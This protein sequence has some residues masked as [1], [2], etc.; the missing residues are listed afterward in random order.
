MIER[1]KKKRKTSMKSQMTVMKEREERLLN[2]CVHFTHGLALIAI[3]AMQKIICQD[4]DVIVEGMKNQ[5]TQ[6]WFCLILVENIVNKKDMKLVH[7]QDAIYFAIQ[8]AAHLVLLKFL[9]LVFAAKNSK[10]FNAKIPQNKNSIA[11]ILV[12]NF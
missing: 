10:E 8:E 5:V 11:I 2:K 7:M 12:A 9:F 1:K 3:I 4:I 6:T